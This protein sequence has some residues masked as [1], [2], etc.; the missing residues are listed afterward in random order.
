MKDEDR[1]KNQ[2]IKELADLRRQ[3]AELKDLVTLNKRVGERLKKSEKIYRS[4]FEASAEGILL[5]DIETLGLKHVNPAICKMLGDCEEELKGMDITN[6]HPKDVLKHIISEVE[7]QAKGEKTSAKEIPCLKKDGK[8]LYADINT[9]KLSIDGSG[10]IL[11]FYRDV[12]ERK[13]ME[14]ALCESEAQKRAI[15]DASIDRIRYVDKDM[16][17]IWANKTTTLGL[18]MSPDDVLGQTCY[19]VFPLW[20]NERIQ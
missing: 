14:E 9:T 2:I 8:I 1:P 6:I 15:L 5:A 17:I 12:T 13:E 3:V 18:D 10:F 11:G 19:K 20:T 7:T 4:I 16:R